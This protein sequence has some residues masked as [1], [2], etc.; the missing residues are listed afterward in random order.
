MHFTPPPGPS[1]GTK[2]SKAS[3]SR[4]ANLRRRRRL[5]W[6]SVSSGEFVFCLAQSIEKGSVIE[7]VI[8]AAG[9]GWPCVLSGRR[10]TAPQQPR[11]IATRAHAQPFGYPCH[12]HRRFRGYGVIALLGPIDNSGQCKKI[13]PPHRIRSITVP[14]DFGAQM[15][16]MEAILSTQR[17][18]PSPAD[19]TLTP[20]R[21]PPPARS[22]RLGIP[23]FPLGQFHGSP[24]LCL[25]PGST[26]MTPC[27]GLH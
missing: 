25:P 1:M 15:D 8:T 24:E 19:S 23:E 7:I 22:S 21:E 20:D 12:R 14:P 9:S 3:T 18:E 2:T 11:Q 5:R 13:V 27:S 26:T 10:A 17:I 6:R 4:S 16:D